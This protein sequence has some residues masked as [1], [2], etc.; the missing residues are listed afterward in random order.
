M[1]TSPREHI[2][3]S[4]DEEH[5]RLVGEILR[6]GSLATA[7][8]EAALAVAERP[9]GA[10]AARIVAADAA[11]DALEREVSHDAMTLS[12]RGPLARD[13]REVLSALRIV[14]DL[15]RIGDHAAG[16]AKRAAALDRAPPAPAADGFA[17]LGAL[18]LRQL[19]DVLAAYRARDALAAQAVRDRDAGLDAEYT[20][21]FRALLAGMTGD[22][23]SV[24]AGTWLLF[25]AKDLE[26][27][28]DHATN[29]AENVWFMVRGDDPLPPR[30]KADRTSQAG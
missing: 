1:T 9:D 19:R 25:M 13:L 15:E 17:R 23:D 27:I 7:Q 6:M 18:A 12:L 3:R 11:I 26:R 22:P 16:I 4:Q 30:E 29:I 21:L 2:V 20:R 8:L 28:G 14:S 24:A 10:A 5:Q